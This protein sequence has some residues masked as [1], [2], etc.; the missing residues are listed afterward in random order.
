[1]ISLESSRI[2]ERARLKNF[3]Q[4]RLLRNF[5]QQHDIY[6][7][8]D[9]LLYSRGYIIITVLYGTTGTL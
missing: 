2:S 7:I 3:F 5:R 6:V 9:D 1:M 4:E 8:T